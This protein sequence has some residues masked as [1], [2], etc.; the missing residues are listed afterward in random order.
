MKTNA[1]PLN[2]LLLIL[3]AVSFVACKKDNKKIVDDIVKLDIQ[4]KQIQNIIPD[5]YLDS[6]KKLGL[7][8]NTGINPVNLEGFY[9]VNPL[10][11]KATNIANDVAIGYRFTDAK[12][13]LF[14]QDENFGI[15]L[16]GKGFLATADTSI[17]TAISGTGKDFTVYG[18]VRSQRNGKQADFAIIISG[19][20]EGN[21]IK[22]FKY[23]LICISNKN[24][25]T[26]ND[27]I[28]EGQARFIVESDQSA[29]RI[30]EKDFIAAKN[31]GSL[32]DLVSP[33][34]IKP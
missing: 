11:L 6:L 28:K 12:L 22:D 25:Q 2:W 33:N 18:K 17:V 34:V 32:L 23:G 7:T 31:G 15:R 9:A 14:N 8:I 29:D 26:N 1:K 21:F 16:I 5:Q 13:K 20:M 30:A 24:I 4:K 10:I 3:L 19:T 27:F